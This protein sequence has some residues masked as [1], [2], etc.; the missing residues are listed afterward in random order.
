M[1]T[2]ACLESRSLN[3]R[4]PED[5]HDLVG[6]ADPEDDAGFDFDASVEAEAEEA[7]LAQLVRVDYDKAEGIKWAIPVAA[8]DSPLAEL[9]GTLEGEDMHPGTR[10]RANSI[11]VLP[12]NPNGESWALADGKP[13]N[14]NPLPAP[15]RGLVV[16]AFDA[17]IPVSYPNDSWVSAMPHLGGGW[18]RTPLAG[19]VIL[20][21]SREHVVAGGYAL[22]LCGETGLTVERVA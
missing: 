18:D 11:L 15:A 1:A 12:A 21:T 6:R 4:V 22:R 16:A 10:H 19:A 5:V 9:T 8:H 14:Q 7:T 3:V 20:D 13:L 17:A 2:R